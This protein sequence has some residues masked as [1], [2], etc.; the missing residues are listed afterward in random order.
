[1]WS[2]S[3]C[4]SDQHD[5]EWRLREESPAVCRRSLR[6]KV[7]AASMREFSE[8][9]D[10]SPPKA[11]SQRRAAKNKDTLVKTPRSAKSSNTSLKMPKLAKSRCTP[12]KTPRAVKS[13]N[14][15]VKTPRVAKS[16]DMPAK[17]T[18][19]AKSKD[20]LF[21]TTRDAREREESPL[22][23]PKASRKL[24]D[25]MKVSPQLRITLGRVKVSPLKMAKLKRDDSP[26]NVVKAVSD[27]KVNFASD[28]DSPSMIDCLPVAASRRR[29]LARGMVI[30]DDEERDEALTLGGKYGTAVKRLEGKH[31]GVRGSDVFGFKRAS[32][33]KV[34][35]TPAR[36]R[37]NTP[38]PSVVAPTASTRTSRRKKAE[39]EKSKKSILPPLSSTVC[40]H[41]LASAETY[42]RLINE[43]VRTSDKTL[44][45]LKTP[46]LSQEEI[47]TLMAKWRDP[48][49]S[50]V[51]IT[52]ATNTSSK[53]HCR[54]PN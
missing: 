47:D 43:R 3:R 1:M 38:V 9:E 20:K 30:E 40:E 48:Y 33:T 22:Y 15:P 51:W 18:T 53:L 23:T 36:S 27:L 49:V 10:V 17:T 25:E 19:V 28:E 54:L 4:K 41:H 12:V 44:S 13:N 2:T 42:F 29:S 16:K 31:Q 11:R 39:E 52:K 34:M 46:K 35:S 5:P 21:K 7:A 32:R 26:E 45:A 6:R 37:S 14:T 8:E 24:K 50:K